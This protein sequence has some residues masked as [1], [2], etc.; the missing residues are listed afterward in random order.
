MQNILLSAP[1]GEQLKQLLP[2]GTAGAASGTIL[3]MPVVVRV[4]FS[5]TS[6]ATAN[7]KWI[8][9]EAGT[10]AAAFH[11]I[12]QGTAGTGTINVGR[13]SDGTG[14]GTNL[15]DSGTLA[16]G[17]HR[18]EPLNGVTGTLMLLGPGGSGTNNSIVGQ[19]TDT[20]TSTMGGLVGFVTYHRI[21][22]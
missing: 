19:V 11:Y 1:E 17:I 2:A 20:V 5:L 21:G 9:P 10:V 15:V 4:A 6:T 13:T 12:V 3:G 14:S 7:F 8:N 22:T 16:S 18:D